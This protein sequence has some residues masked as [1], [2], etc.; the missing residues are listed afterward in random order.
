MEEEELNS[1][2]VSQNG[3]LLGLPRPPLFGI[4][5]IVNLFQRARGTGC[6]SDLVCSKSVGFLSLFLVFL[7][8]LL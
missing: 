2:W 7:C 4:H 3:C 6:I 1:E 8:L 5:S